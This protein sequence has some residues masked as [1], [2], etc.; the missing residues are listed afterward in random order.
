MSKPKRKC[1]EDYS[2]PSN[3]LTTSKEDVL[4]FLLN[5]N[6]D[7]SG[8]LTKE[9]GFKKHFPDL[10]EDFQEFTFPQECD[11][12]TFSHKLYHF[13]R[14]DLEFKLGIC[15]E[16][17]KNRCDFDNFKVG[18]KRFCCT[19][20][21]SSNSHTIELKNQTIIKSY[22][23]IESFNQI[24]L[25][26]SIETN[27]KNHGVDIWTNRDKAEETF[28]DKYDSKSYMGTNE[29]RKK[30]REYYRTNFGCDTNSQ[31]PNRSIIYADSFSKGAIKGFLTKKKNGT[32]TTSSVEQRLVKYLTDSKINF[33]HQYKSDLYP[34][35]CDFYFP[36]YDLYVEIQGH[37]SHG[38][39][40]FNSCSQNDIDTINKWEYKIAN[41]HSQ[42]EHAV[43]IWSK[44][45]PLKR[46][47]AK[48]NNLN[49]LEIFSTD[50]NEC[51]LQIQ[52]KIKE[53]DK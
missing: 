7:T 46:Q 52:Q 34:F 33:I 31:I 26:H 36:D 40:P 18:Y 2:F 9:I 12:W 53:L 37:W 10:Y 45:D 3:Y 50:L 29:F 11:T 6:P 28:M 25:Q 35:A 49:Y 30:S 21:S 8:Y 43:H 15:E 44:R 19:S 47:T 16:C 5:I 17:H 51:I 20:C 4:D 23:S 32:T 38:K 42:Y 27:R 14:D 41:G 13:M 24:R 39:H 1:L 48:D 22:G